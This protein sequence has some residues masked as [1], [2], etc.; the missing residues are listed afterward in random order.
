MSEAE[1]VLLE[2]A[3]NCTLYTIQFLSEDDTEFEQFFN[4]FKD[5]VEFSPDLM[6]IVG[7]PRQD[8][9]LRSLRTLIQ[10]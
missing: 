1:L 9:R 2:E 8:S 6:R 10:T 3:K 4:K 5:D 7:V